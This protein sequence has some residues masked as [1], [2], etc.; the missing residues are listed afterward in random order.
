MVDPRLIQ[1]FRS[2]QALYVG[3]ATEGEREA[4]ASARARLLA[5]IEDDQPEVAPT[6]TLA[7]R[8]P[9]FV[10]LRPSDLRSYPLL[11]AMLRRYG[12]KPVRLVKRRFVAVCAGSKE[13]VVEAL[14]PEFERMG[15]KLSTMIESWA[16]DAISAALFGEEQG[17]V[18]LLAASSS[19][20]E[21]P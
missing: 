21:E 15:R 17:E 7:E 19:Q 2:V 3:A 6:P 18:R 20:E 8:L 1:R 9:L 5:R 14:L 16:I 10:Q 12:L 11:L 4:A 13:V